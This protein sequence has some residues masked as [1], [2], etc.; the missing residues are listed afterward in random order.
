[1]KVRCPARAG[2][3][4]DAGAG[5]RPEGLFAKLSLC[6]ELELTA[7]RSDS[8]ELE[9]ESEEPL[10]SGSANS[11]LRAAAEFR[12]AFKVGRGVRI[13]LVKRI[14]LRSGLAGADS[15]AGAVLRGLASLFGLPGRG[16]VC[17]PLMRLAKKLGPAVPFFVQPASLCR[18]DGDRFTPVLPGGSIPYLVVAFP[19]FRLS[20]EE[21]LREPPEPVE[22]VGLT[23]NSHLDK[24]IRSLEEGLSLSRWEDLL[25]NR[26]EGSGSAEAARVGQVRRILARVGLRGV[27]TAGVGPSAFGFAASHAEGERVLR[28][29]RE[30]PWKV[31]LT[32]CGG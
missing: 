27:R 16:R 17:G 25:F 26:W 3:F 28:T 14:P 22:P 24:L 7:L 4:V 11:V 23:R 10:P 8:V 13:K 32:C 20:S 29:L 1:M 21:A 5:G 31:F 12:K 2:L 19:G 9:V 18:V 15:D 6:D 30:Y